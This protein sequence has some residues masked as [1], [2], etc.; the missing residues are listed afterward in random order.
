VSQAQGKIYAI[1]SLRG[2]EEAVAHSAHLLGRESSHPSR[3][4]QNRVLDCHEAWHYCVRAKIGHLCTTAGIKRVK[5]NG[6]FHVSE[7][8]NVTLKAV[9][10]GPPQR[11]IAHRLQGPVERNK[12]VEAAP[13][14]ALLETLAD[15]RDRVRELQ[16]CDW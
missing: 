11:R 5:C 12:N 6:S 3:N 4:C 7:L 1:L 15:A 13:C 14:A 9:D 2:V 10:G 16:V 8:P